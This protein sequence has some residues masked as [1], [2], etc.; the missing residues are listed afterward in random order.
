[1]GTVIRLSFITHGL[2]DTSPIHVVQ[3]VIIDRAVGLADQSAS[4]AIARA[5]VSIA[6]RAQLNPG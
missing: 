5:V 3:L 4:V 6:C 2:D 1:M